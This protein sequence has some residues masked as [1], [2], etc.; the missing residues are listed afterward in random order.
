MKKRVKLDFKEADL[1]MRFMNLSMKYFTFLEERNL[2]DLI[3]TNAKTAVHHICTLLRLTCFQLKI[4]NDLALVKADLKKTRKGFDHHFIENAV[5]FEAFYSSM[6]PAPSKSAPFS[7]DTSQN[8]VLLIKKVTV[9]TAVVT[10]FRKGI[11]KTKQ[12]IQRLKLTLHMGWQ[13]QRATRMV[14]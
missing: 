8:P 7:L 2:N 14:P 9:V 4:V 5:S 6:V 10:I 3:Q 11:L 1:R 13:M 12:I